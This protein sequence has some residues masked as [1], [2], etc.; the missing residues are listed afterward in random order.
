MQPP[1][2]APPWPHDD[3]QSLIAFYGKPWLDGALLTHVI[4][5]F[6]MKYEGAVIHGILVHRKCADALMTALN[7]CWDHYGHEQAQIDAVGLSN[8]SGSFN[9]RSVRGV[10]RLSCHA[11]GAAID[12]D[13]EH[14]PLGALHGRMAQPVIDAFK[15]VGCIWGGDFKSRKD[16]MHFQFAHE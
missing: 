12:I 2:N 6:T 3:Q 15:S 8:Y 14:N 16:W 11:F 9:Y 13:A 1:A 5:P 7:T 10:S 4:P